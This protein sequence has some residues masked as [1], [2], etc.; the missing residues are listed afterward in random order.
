MHIVVLADHAYITGGQS[1]V[2]IES[3]VGLAGRGH[4][5]TYFAAVGP[6]DPKLAAAGIATLCLD[7]GDINTASKAAF[8]LQ[9][10]W[11]RKAAQALG[12]F[13]GQC[14]IGRAHV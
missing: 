2:A 13:L 12:D 3:A 11:N 7:Q 1:K 10:M 14:E 8:L 6:V 5:V 9:T 4:R